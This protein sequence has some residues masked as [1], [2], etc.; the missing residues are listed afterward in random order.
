[1]SQTVTLLE[2]HRDHILTG[3]FP[4][5]TRL[6]LRQIAKLQDVCKGPTIAAVA[7]LKEVARPFQPPV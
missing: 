7:Q 6:D 3:N 5:G 1:M 4:L 2:Y